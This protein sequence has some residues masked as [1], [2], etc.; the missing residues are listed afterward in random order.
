M[1]FF[2]PENFLD[3]A[4]ILKDN[5][6][7]EEQ[8]K[9]RTV[10]GRAY[11]AAFLTTREYLNKYK[12]ISFHKERQHQEVIDALDDL[13]KFDLKNWLES[14]RDNR[15]I[16]D[17]YLDMELDMNKCEKSIVLSEEIINSLEGF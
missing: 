16:A 13:D 11:Y 1:S 14:L 6:E 4:R 2:N 10:I 8:G 12:G 17:Y 7:M 9:I 5:I 15:V 3:I